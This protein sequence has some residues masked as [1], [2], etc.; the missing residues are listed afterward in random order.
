MSVTDF[1][2]SYDGLRHLPT[3]VG[4]LEKIGTKT[5]ICKLFAAAIIA[6]HK[7]EETICKQAGSLLATNGEL[8]KQCELTRKSFSDNNGNS[9][10]ATKNPNADSGESYSNIVKSLVVKPKSQSMKFDSQIVQD[11][12]EEALR[13][14]S[15]SSTRLTKQENLMLN[16][17]NASSR[18]LAAD[19]LKSVFTEDVEFDDL[20]RIPPKL[21]IVGLPS[22]FDPENLTK[23]LCEKDEN[24]KNMIENGEDIQL[25][26]NWDMK[27]SE[28]VITS[29][30]IAVKVSPNI[31]HHLIIRN[32]GYIYVKLARYRV[33]DRV[34]VTQCYH[35]YAYGHI[36]KNCPDKLKDPTCGKCAK[37]HDTRNCRSTTEKC[38]N[39]SKSTTKIAFDHCAF[40]YKCLIHETERKYLISRTDY[41]PKNM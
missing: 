17:P 13:Q 29:K 32:Q 35:C 6:L 30:K 31:R 15:V 36:A 16:L 20:R 38:R 1:S 37:S 41:E 19:K 7:A 26:H 23:E 3:D 22:T 12:V 34:I 4:K 10:N 5:D 21:T 28:G 39:C 27:N 2:R 14:V 11:K 33:Y 25:L 8:L 18:D 9:L 24:L 40:S